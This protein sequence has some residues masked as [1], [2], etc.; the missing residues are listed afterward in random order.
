MS[1]LIQIAKPSASFALRILLCVAA[2]ANFDGVVHAAELAGS[3]TELSGGLMVRKSDGTPKIQGIAS[4]IEVGDTVITPKSSFARIKL[5]DQSTITLKSGTTLAIHRFMFNPDMPAKHAVELSLEKGGIHLVSAPDNGQKRM[6]IFIKTNFGDLNVTGASGFI[7]VT[8][9]SASQIALVWKYLRASTASLGQERSSTYSDTMRAR[10]GIV[11]LP[12][13]AQI[14]LPSGLG[15]APGLYVHVIDGMINLTNKGGAQ[16]FSAGQFGYT[17]SSVQPPVIVPPN[18][19]IKFTPP[20]I[21][22]S[23]SSPST[24]TLPKSN[25]VDCEVR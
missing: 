18:P 2:F 15:L 11:P 23:S 16:L 20:P 19:G 7:A 6:E 1:H 14:T 9:A 13:L 21:F 25:A 12:M 4:T 22:S 17:A 5:R 10:S 3:V 8:E 24:T